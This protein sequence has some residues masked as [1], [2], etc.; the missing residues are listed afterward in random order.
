MLKKDKLEGL[1]TPN[2]KTYFK[3]TVTKMVLYQCRSRC[4]IQWDTIENPK[5]NYI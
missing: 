2:I 1:K 5:I 4:I 3:A